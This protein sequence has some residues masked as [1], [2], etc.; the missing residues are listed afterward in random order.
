[1]PFTHGNNLVQ[2]ISSAAFD[3]TLGHAVLPR[4][5]KGGPY[6]AHLQGSN[7]R[8]DFHPVLCIPIEDQKPGCRLKRK[9][10]PQLLDNPLARRMPCDVEV[11][12]APTIMTDDKETV[13]HTERRGRNREEIPRGNNL[14]VISKKSE[15]QLSWVRGPRGSFHPTG[16]RSLGNI[17]T[18]HEKL[19]VDARCASSRVLGDHAE[20]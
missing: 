9:R 5:S 10:L 18:E 14:A 15:P 19:A 7:G 3:P 8:R 20:D 4:T 6:G 13:E 12:N 11:Q 17:E 16:D 2:E 1:M